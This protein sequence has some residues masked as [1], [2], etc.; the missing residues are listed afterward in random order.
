MLGR[1]RP[2]VVGAAEASVAAARGKRVSEDLLILSCLN[3]SEI[4]I[5]GG[6]S[7]EERGKLM[8]R[9]LFEHKRIPRQATRVELAVR[10]YRGYEASNINIARAS[11]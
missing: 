11:R 9:A 4:K 8:E 7:K 5:E 10:V 3:W 6:G 2:V 1:A